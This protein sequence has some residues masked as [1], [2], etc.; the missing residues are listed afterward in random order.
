MQKIF[1]IHRLMDSEIKHHHRDWN[2]KAA[3]CIVDLVRLHV[4]IAEDISKHDAMEF[5]KNCGELL[6]KMTTTNENELINTFLSSKP[7]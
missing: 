5:Q 7:N 6:L 1:S 4:N 2:Q 3:M